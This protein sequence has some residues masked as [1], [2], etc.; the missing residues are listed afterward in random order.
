M[1]EK[2][3]FNRALSSLTSKYPGLRKDLKELKTNKRE[4]LKL[5]RWVLLG[6]IKKNIREYHF[7]LNG[8]IAKTLALLDS[9]VTE[10]DK[11]NPYT[12]NMILRAQYESLAAVHYYGAHPEKSQ[13]LTFGER[14]TKK[15]ETP[16]E[17]VHVNDMIK[18]LEKNAPK[19]W[20][21]WKDIDNMS[22]IIHPNKQ[23]HQANITPKQEGVFE[24]SSQCSMDENQ[25]KNLLKASNNLVTSILNGVSDVDEW[26]VK[27]L[28]ITKQ[29]P[30]KKEV[31][32]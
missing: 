23:S 29:I 13:N 2:T 31:I 25:I 11:Q 5:F 9:L 12:S 17:A 21:V 14:F 16:I 8:I 1:V 20:D 22:N 27:N 15:D 28:K 18:E 10:L 24:F 4:A 3:Y 30:Q 32:K 19:T 26:F 6:D 7:F